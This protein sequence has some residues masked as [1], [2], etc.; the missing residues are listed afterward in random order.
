[1]SARVAVSTEI[2]ARGRTRLAFQ[3]GVA[4]G[5]ALLDVV[6]VAPLRS[7]RARDVPYGAAG[8]V[9]E[10]RALLELAGG[11]RPGPGAFLER[12]GDGPGA[13]V[14]DAAA[15]PLVPGARAS[16]DAGSLTLEVRVV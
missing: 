7:V 11:G 15:L 9:P 5:D 13:G 10:A 16:V 3:I 2:D 8:G 14:M 1:M 12:G 6:H 4:W